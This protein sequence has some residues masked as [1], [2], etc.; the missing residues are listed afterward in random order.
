LPEGWYASSE[1]QSPGNTGVAVSTAAIVDR[2]AYWKT[3]R[4]KIFARL[5]RF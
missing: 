2:S 5:V 1:N 3:V 4:P